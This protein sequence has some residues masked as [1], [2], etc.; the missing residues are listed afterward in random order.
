MS[1]RQIGI[2]GYGAIGQSLYEAIDNGRAGQCEAVAILCRNI[3][4]YQGN[5]PL[6]NGQPILT[7]DADHFFDMTYDIVIEAAGQDALRHYGVRV[8]EGGANFLVT[9]IGA[10]TDDDFFAELIACADKYN[11]QLL[12]AS[13]ALPGVDWM[14]SAALADV[15]QVMITQTKPV[16]SWRGTPAEQLI[17]LNSLT[18]PT[19]FFE[20][21]AR[22]AASQFPK[23]SNITAMLALSTIGLDETNVKIFAD[24]T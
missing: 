21:T 7:D 17:D 8:L 9:S 18:E 6:R 3:D 14:T 4:N 5:I 13:G 23:S 11:S 16:A 24:P 15:D 22:Q 19:S 10:F 1:R 2:L 12:L 20:G